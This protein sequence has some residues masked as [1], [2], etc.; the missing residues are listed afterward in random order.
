MRKHR[1]FLYDIVFVVVIMIAAMASAVLE[2]AAVLGVFPT[3]DF[4]PTAARGAGSEA[5]R[6]AASASP[7]DGALLSAAA[8][9]LARL[10]H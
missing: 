6:P 5:A 10:G 9:R 3:I 7:V 2:A 8:P 1:S 4:T